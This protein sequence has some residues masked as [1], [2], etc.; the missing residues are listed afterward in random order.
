MKSLPKSLVNAVSGDDLLARVVVTFFGIGLCGLGFPLLAWVATG[1]LQGQSA[2]VVAL[3]WV[4]ALAPTTYGFILVLR[5][6][7]SPGLGVSRLADHIS[8][9]GSGGELLI[10]LLLPAVIVTLLLRAFGVRGRPK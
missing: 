4:L 9:D 5:A 6:L 7:G 3:A 8:P 10:L 2:W 1:G